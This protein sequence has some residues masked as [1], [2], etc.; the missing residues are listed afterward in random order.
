MKKLFFLSIRIPVEYIYLLSGIVLPCVI[1]SKRLNV[2]LYFSKSETLVDLED[3]PEDFFI[4]KKIE[5]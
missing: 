1:S 4:Y 3:D 5:G 2:S